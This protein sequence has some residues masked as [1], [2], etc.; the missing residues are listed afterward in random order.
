MPTAGT[1]NW[2]NI[3]PFNNAE[4]HQAMETWRIKCE[5]RRIDMLQP[6]EQFDK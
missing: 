3:D 6:F 2:S 1:P 5:Q 4:L